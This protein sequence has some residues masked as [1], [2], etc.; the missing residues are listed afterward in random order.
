METFGTEHQVTEFIED[1]IRNNYDLTPAGIIEKL[2]RIGFVE[3]SGK[4]K[5]KSLVPTEKGKQMAAALPEVLRSPLMTAQWEQELLK[6][7]NGS[8]PADQFMADIRQ[9]TDENSIC[10]RLRELAMDN[11]KRQEKDNISAIW[12]KM[13]S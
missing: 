9:M 5:T 4:G 2:I 7:E 3:R 10:R 12:L 6:V 8:M 13:S 11:L 1:F